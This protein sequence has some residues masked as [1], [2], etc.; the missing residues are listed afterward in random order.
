LGRSFQPPPGA[1]VIAQEANECKAPNYSDL[2]FGGELINFRLRAWAVSWSDAYAYPNPYVYANPDFHANPNTNV[3]VNSDADFHA[4]SNPDF[5][6]NI[7][8]YFHPNLDPHC[9]GDTHSQSKADASA[10]HAATIAAMQTDINFTSGGRRHSFI[11]L[12]W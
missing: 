9:H 6:S 4:N 11:Q 12:P 3:Y 2:L 10:S 8:T 7:H 5:H 1:P